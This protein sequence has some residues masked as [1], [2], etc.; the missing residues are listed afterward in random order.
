MAQNESKPAGVGF[1]Q[2]YNEAPSP[3]NDLNPAFVT[4]SSESVRQTPAAAAKAPKAAKRAKAK[5]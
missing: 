5:K 2:K 3:T 4:G 1:P